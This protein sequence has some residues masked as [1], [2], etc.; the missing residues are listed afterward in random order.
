MALGTQDKEP[1]GLYSSAIDNFAAPFDTRPTQASRQTTN[2]MDQ[3]LRGMAPPLGVPK[4]AAP[5]A[6]AAAGP[7]TQMSQAAAANYSASPNRVPTLPS[8]MPQPVQQP[9]AAPVIPPDVLQRF[10]QLQSPN[11][12][13]EPRGPNLISPQ[14]IYQQ[15]VKSGPIT[16]AAAA[17]NTPGV[18]GGTVSTIPASAFTTR[19]PADSRAVSEALQA[20]AARGDWDAIR[21]HYQSGDGQGAQTG[22]KGGAIGG[23]AEAEAQQRNEM[24]ARWGA[25]SALFKLG[26]GKPGKREAETAQLAIQQ[27][28]DLANRNTK[29]GEQADTVGLAQQ[30]LTQRAAEN[31][32]QLAVEHA[33]LAQG[34]PAAAGQ[35]LQNQQA[36][37]MM[38]LTRKA[39]GGDQEALRQLQALQGKNPKTPQSEA[40]LE[41]LKAYTTG[42]ATALP[43]SGVPITQVMQDVAPLLQM[44]GGQAPAAAA[45]AAPPADGTR[46]TLNGVRGVIRNG[47]FIPD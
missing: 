43:G 34:Q 21:Q 10:A 41:I 2:A 12:G 31:Q 47:Q 13:L 17:K 1:R 6:P 8:A 3:Q 30:E 40:L 42:Q 32:Q 9:P 7:I 33:K 25:D 19:T 26:I 5:A 18:S 15:M 4:V 11:M 46:G 22:P 27:Y 37:M 38:D 16:Q 23:S 44:L 36:Q 20:A 24:F 35:Q 28:A 29:Q 14:E 39:I 45:P